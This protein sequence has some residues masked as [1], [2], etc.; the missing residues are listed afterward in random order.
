[1][2]DDPELPQTHT[3]DPIATPPMSRRSTTAQLKADIDSGAT[4]DKTPDYDPGLSQLGTD[5]EA[6]GRPPSAE[7]ID[8]ARYH[9][10]FSRWAQ[11]AHKTIGAHEM[12][13]GSL[14]GFASFIVAVGV[15]LVGGIWAL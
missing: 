13:D 9:E 10:R 12:W 2:A 6:A 7:R 3:T 4:G 15:I 11:G 8:L 14:T 5:D 1:M